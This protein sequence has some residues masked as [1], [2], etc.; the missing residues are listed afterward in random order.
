MDFK[1]EYENLK[2][3]NNNNQSNFYDIVNTSLRYQKKNS[4]F[5]FELSVNN[6]LDNKIK[7]IILF[8][9]FD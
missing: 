1:F 8:G 2:N 6:L 9:L 3:T 7:T 5:G 4:A